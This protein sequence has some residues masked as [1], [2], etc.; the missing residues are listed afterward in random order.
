M[1]RYIV[2]RVL[3]AI[4]LLFLITIVTYFLMNLAPGGPLA[5]YLHNPKV[6]PAVLHRLSI[7]M[8]LNQPWY[9]R[10]FAWLWALLHGNW[11]YSYF[12]GQSVISLIG[13]RLPNTLILMGASFLIAL[14]IGIPLGVYVATHQ[15]SAQDHAFSFLS[16]FAWAMPSF[17]FGLLL[18]TIFAVKF[19]WFPVSG[20]YS[21]YEPP[22]LLELLWH[23]VLPAT[24]LGL[25]SLAGWSRYM[26]SGILEVIR[27]DYVRTARAKGLNERRV[28]WKHA[29][30][31]ALL[32]IVTI[33]G[34]ELPGFFGG[35]VITEEIFAWPG[36]GR[37]FLSALNN[38]DYPVEMAGLLISAVLLVVGNLLADLAYSVLD[39]RI[40][41]R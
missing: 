35:A 33:L 3:E 2:Q 8:G 4:P 16:F 19:R 31:N 18:Q 37:L 9:V 11:G 34:L 32:P 24:V 25:G 41:Y 10:Y 23:S 36:M 6:T 29:F 14:L 12:S 7:Q 28:I 17:F 15:Y 20:M 22:S 13:Q 39:P 38:R 40:Q 27:Q 26:R 5:V 30:K 1:S 21:V